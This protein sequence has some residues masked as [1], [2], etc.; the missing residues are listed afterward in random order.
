M[1]SPS[2]W[3]G[4]LRLC[5]DNVESAELVFVSRLN[6]PALSVKLSRPLWDSWS[7]ITEQSVGTQLPIRLDGTVIARPVVE[8]RHE[9]GQLQVTGPE[10]GALLRMAERVLTPC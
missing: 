3:V 7:K 8:E 10:R 4:P 9:A 1:E 5:R 6:Q 2:A